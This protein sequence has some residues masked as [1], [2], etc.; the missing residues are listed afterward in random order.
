MISNT[1]LKKIK[2]MMLKLIKIKN[3]PQKIKYKSRI[4]LKK[5]HKKNER[6]RKKMGIFVWKRIF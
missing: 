5:K 3:N 4:S 1:T 6:R 2:N